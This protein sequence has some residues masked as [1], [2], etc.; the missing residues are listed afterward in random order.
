MPIT[1]ITAHYLRRDSD[2]AALL[3]LRQE[4]LSIDEPKNRLLDQLKSCFLGRLN[5]EHGS[6]SCDGDAENSMLA[7]TLRTFLADEQDLTQSTT[8]IM[9]QMEL[10]VN[11]AEME[12]NAHFLFFVEQSGDHHHV[13][14]LFIVH[15]NE[16]LAISDQLDVMPSY[17]ID[18]GPSLAC[19]KVD[20]MEWLV[21]KNYAYLTLSSP[22]G[23]PAL[24]DA[25]EKLTGFSH[26]INKKEA[27]KSFLDGVE[28]FAKQLPDDKAREYREQVVGYCMAQ[29][30]K[31]EPVNIEALSR[32]LVDIDRESFVRELRT[33][34]PGEQDELMVD[35]SSLRRF[36]KFAG[37]DKDL[38]ITFSTY[39]LHSRVAYE[40]ESDT[41][42]IKGLPK[43][44]RTQLLAYQER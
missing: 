41:L 29:D 27:T 31:D 19:I 5:R 9:K 38:S 43:A 37:R 4:P 10:L 21:H 28:S 1:H 32:E 36:V 20:I 30:E 3:S 22:R 25:L 44:L 11:E 34:H 26:G 16:S 18:T 40:M 14:Y 39:H 33:H 6:F 42:T 23:K 35:R 13:F 15:Q 12:I 2:A 24:C 7:A 17:T 8:A